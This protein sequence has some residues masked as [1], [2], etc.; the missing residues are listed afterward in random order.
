M[1]ILKGELKGAEQALTKVMTSPTDFK[2]AYRLEK[3]L[4]KVNKELMA[5]EKIRVDLITKHGEKD[6]KG[7]GMKVGEAN[8][9]IF[10]KEYSAFLEEELD[11][12]ISPIPYEL[13]ERS[14]IRIA[15]TD[16]HALGKLIDVPQVE[17]S[18]KTEIKK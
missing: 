8:M 1:K 5:I 15:A 7:N 13:L 16:I 4:G 2:L 12:D 11:L 17:D 3:I 14:G 10:T 18:V 6:E 9:E